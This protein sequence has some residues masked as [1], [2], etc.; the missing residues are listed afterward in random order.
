MPYSLDTLYDDTAQIQHSIDEVF[1]SGR[2]IGH[3][4]VLTAR[5]VIEPEGISVPKKDGWQVRLISSRPEVPA[6]ESWSWTA[7]SVRWSGKE[8]GLDLALLQLHPPPDSV[9]KPKLEL[10]IGLIEEVCHR[11]VRGLGFPR[12]ARVENKRTLLAPSGT[13]DDERGATLGFGIDPTYQPESPTADWCG[14]SGAAVFLA[15]SPNHNVIWIY[16]VAR[17]VPPSFTHRIDVERLAKA[18]EDD[19]FRA[20]LRDA[21]ISLVEPADP[22]AFSAPQLWAQVAEN[23]RA[24]VEAITKQ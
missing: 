15:D 11:P 1:G 14:F 18:W 5:H 3:N 23:C 19:N 21:K 17:Q 6:V 20:A 9:L 4:L 24:N 7:A 8:D 16:G 22:I 10:R 2:L 13:L 12:G